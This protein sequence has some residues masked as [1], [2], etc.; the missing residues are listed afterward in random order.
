MLY[1]WVRKPVLPMKETKQLYMQ[2]TVE[3][4]Q[5]VLKL[6]KKGQIKMRNTNDHQE[7]IQAFLEKR[8][9]TF[10]GR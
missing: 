10:A 9:P 8:L 1:E 3:E 7:G 2:Q 5:H 4:L 6:E